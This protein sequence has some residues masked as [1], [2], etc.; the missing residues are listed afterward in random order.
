MKGAVNIDFNLSVLDLFV[1]IGFNGSLLWTQQWT[2]HF[3]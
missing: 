1:R 3:T 2:P